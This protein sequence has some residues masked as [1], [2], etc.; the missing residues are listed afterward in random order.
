VLG[1]RE[2][3]LHHGLRQLDLLRDHLAIP[4]ERLRVIVNGVGAPGAAS[5][6][7]VLDG[8]TSFLAE[9]GVS[10]DAWLPWDGRALAR[11]GHSGTPLVL[12]RK[13]GSYAR[14]MTRLLDE[15]F[16]PATT[17]APRQRKHRLPVTL[18]REPDE[19]ETVVWQR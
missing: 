6:R 19:K 5:R 1:A 15:L 3:Q 13:R 9:R 2:A 11:A 16:M 14:A 18:T 8:A 17:P 7:A 4:P 12:A 10:I